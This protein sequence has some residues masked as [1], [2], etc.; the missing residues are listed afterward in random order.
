MPRLTR[1]GRGELVVLIKVA[2]P[3]NLTPEQEELLEKL[4]ELRSEQ[5]DEGGF[6]SKIREAFS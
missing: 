6:F 3:T 4:A 5:V 2:T 1:P